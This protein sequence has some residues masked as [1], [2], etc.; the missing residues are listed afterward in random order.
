MQTVLTR[1]E[2][3]QNDPEGGRG[4]RWLCP[5][6]S[7]A[8]HTA[9]RHRSL[10]LDEGGLW[11]C[12]RCKASGRLRENWKPLATTRDERRQQERTRRRIAEDRALA[13]LKAPAPSVGRGLSRYRL[14]TL[15]A[16]AEPAAAEGR[17]YLEGRGLP[18]ELLTSAGVRFA[19]DFMRR[20]ATDE[21]PAW[22]GM[23]AVVFPL[24]DADGKP[25]AAQGR[26]VREGASP[27]KLTTEGD[28]RRLG[29]FATPGAWIDPR[30]PLAIV[31]APIDALTLCAAGL[32][33]V[34]LCG[35]AG[36]P[37][38]VVTRLAWRERVWLAFDGDEAGDLAA[39]ALAA[40]LAAATLG[41]CKT[42][43]LR[44]PE[45]LKD[46]NELLTRSGLDAL[47]AVLPALEAQEAPEP[48]MYPDDWKS[49]PEGATGGRRRPARVSVRWVDLDTSDLEPAPPPPLP[50]PEGAEN[51]KK[52]ENLAEI[53]VPLEALGALVDAELVTIE[54][55]V[56][57]S[58]WQEIERGG[59]L[60]GPWQVSHGVTV[61]DPAAWLRRQVARVEVLRAENAGPWWEGAE[62]QRIAAALGQLAL[63]LVASRAPEKGNPMAGEE[64]AA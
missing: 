36:L 57:L 52:P 12:H 27:S 6:P 5:L 63:W 37:S 42:E 56:L 13:T 25:V 61:K 29:V 55:N 53:G 44:P 2:I 60:G 20:A 47:R 64:K 21:R 30:S 7:C 40:N 11:N 15:W 41:R 24:R 49:A 38:W 4:G 33:A 54:Q 46:W 10:H 50:L 45:G 9:R 62:G 28:G 59:D 17:R 23:P 39:Q 16:L 43:R 22:R 1:Q 14:G 8:G 18:L 19:L 31:E 48:E 58:A 3:E 35:T 51:L 34:A 26:A 32:E